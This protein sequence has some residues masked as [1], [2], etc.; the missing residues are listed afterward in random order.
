MSK[1][2]LF[3]CLGVLLSVSVPIWGEQILPTDDATWRVNSRYDAHSVLGLFTKADGGADRAYLQF[4]LGAAPVSLAE[5]KLYSYWG[6]S[7]GGA[8][9]NAD[10]RIR[11]ISQSDAGYV[12]W[13]E[14]AGP[15]PSGTAHES[16]D[17]LV[18]SFHVN[19]TPQWFTFDVTDF[20][21]ANLGE[22]VTMSLRCTYNEDW[23]YDG[24]IFVDKEGIQG[25][26]NDLSPHILIPEP[27]GLLL[28]LFGAVA[29]P[30]RRR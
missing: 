27:T 1:G 4:Q 21:N 11:G 22:K 5:L 9:V 23:H 26:Y 29:L 19:D 7:T 24:P 8:T 15:A 6:T 10:V 2:R 3:V 12:N 28:A 13:T 17:V 18:D 20:Y 30:R 16:W 14:E 25:H